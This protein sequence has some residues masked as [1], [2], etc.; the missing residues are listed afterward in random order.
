MAA[1]KRAE[2]GA[3]PLRP[4]MRD[5]FVLSTCLELLD[6]K[7]A[8][9]FRDFM[10][11]EDRQLTPSQMETVLK[12]LSKCENLDELDDP[13]ALDLCS[14]VEEA[15]GMLGNE[16]QGDH[17]LPKDSAVALRWHVLGAMANTSK[18]R[19]AAKEALENRY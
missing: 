4:H 13:K 11:A 2:L 9:S 16:N 10:R 17:R 5:A 7:A 15:T 18:W 3:R 14:E 1:K 19:Q 8:L 12:L 6:H